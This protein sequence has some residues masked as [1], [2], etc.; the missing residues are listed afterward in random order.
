MGT[1]AKTPEMPRSFG[2]PLKS[3]VSVSPIGF[4]APKYRSAE[5][6]VRRTDYGLGNGF[7]ESPET[8]GK[9]K[10]VKNAASTMNRDS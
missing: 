6:E 4:S 9:S 10:M 8:K 5:E 1:S 3:I 2:L 7:S